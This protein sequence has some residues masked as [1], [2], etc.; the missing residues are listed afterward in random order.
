MQDS[1][2]TSSRRQFLQRSG[3]LALGVAAAT[4]LPMAHAAPR[5]PAGVDS[6]PLIYLSPLHADGRL[7]KCQAEIW[8]AHVNDAL[9]VVT[10]SKSWRA[11]AAQRGMR[12]RIWVGDVGQ[13]RSSDGAYLELPAVD[14][15]SATETDATT[16]L[17]VLGEMGV[18]YSAE[19]GRWGPRFR[20]GLADGSRVMLRYWA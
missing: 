5:Y 6:S 17:Q 7:S 4:A 9:Y 12:T 10:S 13:W 18:K 14:L 11:K 16:Q 19:W 2:S 3:T 1:P 15:R 8:Y 20:D